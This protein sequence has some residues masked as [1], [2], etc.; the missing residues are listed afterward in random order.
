MPNAPDITAAETWLIKT[1]L[2]QRYGEDI[3]VEIVET[4]MRLLPG[5]RELTSCQA[6]YWTWNECHFI[7]CKTADRRYRSQFF[8][9][10]REKY[11][12]GIDEYTDIT[13]CVVTL[14][15]VHTQFEAQKKADTA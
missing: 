6:V 10:V 14:I 15:D 5:D 7:I 13:E 11:G 4:E 8:F 3:D 2:K 12:T 9:S 1:S